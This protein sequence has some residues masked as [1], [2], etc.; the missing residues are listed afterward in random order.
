MS[1]FLLRR[2]TT[3]LIV[4]WGVGTLVFLLIHFIPGD[5]IEAMLGETAQQTDIED[6]RERLGLNQPLLIQYKNYFLGLIQGD[7]GISIAS[8]RKVTQEIWHHFPATAELALASIVV[9]LL[10]SFPLGIL[11]AVKK[12]SPWDITA[13]VVSTLGLAI[14]NFWLGPLLIILFSIKFGIFPVSGRG[15]IAH[16]ILPAITLGTAL[17]ALLTRIIKTSVVEEL[18]EDYVR[19]ALAKGLSKR[20]VLMKHVLRNA[21]IPIVTIMGLQIGSLLTGAIITE[22]IFSWPGIGRLI[23]RAINQRDYPL[24]QGVIIFIAF[25]YISVN[26]ITDIVYAIIDPR[27]RYEASPR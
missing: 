10:V 15:S 7:L 24:V 1:R 6:L 27:I 26:F 16:L 17:A 5:P 4:L 19:T 20:K 8:G 2:F 9:A 25:I 14:P 12:D 11:A 13:T 23:I 3:T 22:T 18:R 21:L